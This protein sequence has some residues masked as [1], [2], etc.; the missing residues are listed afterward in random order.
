M[1][2]TAVHIAGESVHVKE[3]EVK[4]MKQIFLD[5][6]P[7]PFELHT[8]KPLSCFNFT[9]PRARAESVAELCGPDFS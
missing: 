7:D 5:T 8:L 4:V 3:A 9:H 1:H 2:L 6:H